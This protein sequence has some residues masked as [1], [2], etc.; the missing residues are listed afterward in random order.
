MAKIS[1]GQNIPFRRNSDLFLKCSSLLSF[2]LVSL[3]GAAFL[4]A[5][6]YT[7]TNQRFRQVQIMYDWIIIMIF[8]FKG[9]G[10][11]NLIGLR[12]KTLFIWQP[13][14]MQILLF[15]TKS[16]WHKITFGFYQGTFNLF[17]YFFAEHNLVTFKLFITIITCIVLSEALKQ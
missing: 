8:L 15:Y 7:S 5:R 3:V 11:P 1:R 16:S 13:S 10:M 14:M 4:L 17:F 2:I 9:L 6:I 12:N